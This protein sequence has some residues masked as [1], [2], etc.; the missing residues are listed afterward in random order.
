MKK[1]EFTRSM[2]VLLTSFTEVV[3]IDASH[4]APA[5]LAVFGL[6]VRGLFVPFGGIVELISI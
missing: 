1:K 6:F 3:V 2:F 4:V 5:A